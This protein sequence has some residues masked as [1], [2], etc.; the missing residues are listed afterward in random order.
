MDSMTQSKWHVFGK[1]FGGEKK[2]EKCEE[3]DFQ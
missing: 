3:I 2:Q 1:G